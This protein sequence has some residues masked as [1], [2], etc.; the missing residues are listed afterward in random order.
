[1]PGGVA[2]RAGCAGAGRALDELRQ[3]PARARRER[4]PPATP[5]AGQARQRHGPPLRLP[6]RD[7]PHRAR[8][9]SLAPG[10]AHRLALRRSL[11]GRWRRGCLPGAHAF[12]FASYRRGVFLTDLRGGERLVARGRGLHP[13]SFTGH[14]DLLVSGARSISLVAPR[15]TVLRRFAYRP[16]NGF[17]FDDRTGTL[18]YVTRAGRLAA[19]RG[20]RVELARSLRDVDG[21]LSVARPN[22]LVFSGARSITATRRDGTVVAEA[23]WSSRRVGSDSGVAVAP[24]GDA[25]VFR[26]SDAHPGSRSSTATVYLLRAGASRAQAIYRHQLGPSG[27]AV[28][29]S[30][31]WHGTSLLYSS[32]DGTLALVDTRTAAVTE[33]TT[34]ARTLPRHAAGERAYAGWRGDFRR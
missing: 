32:S 12:A 22:L 18:Y 11:P 28:G 21:L 26:L 30:L 16:R 33:L 4:Q 7:P 31:S 2:A 29:A 20:V 10:R 25:F 6:P 19:A 9:A 17:G 13:Y 23:S 14:G 1:V 27:C 8:T 15:G 3:L 24:A 5:L 34:L